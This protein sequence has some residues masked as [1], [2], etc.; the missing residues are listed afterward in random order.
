VRLCFALMLGVTMTACG[1]GA[2]DNSPQAQCEQQAMNDPAVVEI[3]SRTNG[4]YTRSGTEN[5]DLVAAKRQATLR[6]LRQK[7]L[8][9]PGGVQPVRLR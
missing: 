2:P 9:P 7:G 5:A 1:F 4:A 8:A 3:Y 6:C